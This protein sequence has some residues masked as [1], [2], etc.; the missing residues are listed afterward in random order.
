[1]DTDRTGAEGLVVR[2]HGTAG[3]VARKAAISRFVNLVGSTP[4]AVHVPSTL[5][6]HPL[7]CETSALVRWHRTMGV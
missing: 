3:E 7:W 2:E 6:I 1:M 5:D 4:R